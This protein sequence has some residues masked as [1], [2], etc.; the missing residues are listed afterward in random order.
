MRF[1]RRTLPY[2]RDCRG[3][4]VYFGLP[5]IIVMFSMSYASAQV[6]TTIS[7]ALPSL[8][9]D[10]GR[11]TKEE[12]TSDEGNVYCRPPQPLTDSRL[13]GPQVC[14]SIRKWND[15]HAHDLDIDARGQVKPR[16]GLDNLKVL[17]H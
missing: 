10:E 9:G 16:Q 13:M 1:I 8:N 3:L 4:S 12:R 14:M 15:L 17:N 7:P 6:Q 2:A 5:I 11:S